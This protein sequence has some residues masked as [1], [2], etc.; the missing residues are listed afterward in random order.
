MKTAYLFCSKQALNDATSYYVRIIKEA[1]ESKGINYYEAH[2]LSELNNAD[3]IITITGKYF[4][5]SKLRYPFKKSIFWAQGIAAEEA[6]MGNYGR[7]S[8]WGRYICE[9][10]AVKRSNVLF[11]V[12]QRMLEFYKEKYG[13][14]GD[15]YVVMPCFNKQ[16][17]VNFDLTQYREP[18]FVY[19]GSFSVW[20]GVDLML[21]VYKLVEEQLPGSKLTILSNQ[22]EQFEK[23]LINNG[24]KNYSIKYVSLEALGQELHKY[25]YG[26]ILR[27]D[28]IVNNVSTPTKMNSYL[29]VYIIPL[30]SDAVNDF[31]DNIKL[32]PFTLMFK[33]PLDAH[34]IASRIVEFE[35]SNIDYLEY[36][37]YVEK[38]FKEHYNEGLYKGI[39]LE[40][41]NKIF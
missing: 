38:V 24:I 40:K 16:I 31:A 11:V 10:T 7:L 8:F 28:H 1:L 32:G 19:A 15:N 18:T 5:L 34:M 6:K 30:F 29:S 9:R 13:Y 12:S 41:I 22:K 25:K 17:S 20:Q 37:E 36:K 4:M 33:C 21:D 2:C 35:K 3:I 23:K 39:I 26:F 27:E 14:Q